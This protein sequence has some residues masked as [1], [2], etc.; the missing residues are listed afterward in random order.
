MAHSH[1]ENLIMQ[2]LVTYRIAQEAVNQ[3]CV[4]IDLMMKTHAVKREH[5]HIVVLDTA[6]RFEQ[7]KLLPILYQHSVGDTTKWEYD[8]A[9]FAREKAQVSWRTGLDTRIVKYMMPQL[10]EQGDVIYA[11]GVC[12][13]G[14]VVACSGVE[15]EYD[16]VFARLIAS[17]IEAKVR[18][19]V[20]E[21]QKKDIDYVR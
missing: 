11:G 18:L 6:E 4:L 12:Y 3:A 9:R 21:M 16:E 14:I 10:Y 13:D 2:G 7:G 1:K 19:E 5:L 17:L 20:Q 15:S 8:Y